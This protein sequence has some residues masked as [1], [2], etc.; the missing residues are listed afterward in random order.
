M[1]DT[2]E[3]EST[4]SEVDRMIETLESNVESDQAPT[5]NGE[6]E[7]DNPES[8]SE[9]GSEE[10]QNQTEETAE[11]EQ[12]E[13]EGVESTKQEEDESDKV[14]EL[15][16][17]IEQ[18]EEQLESDSQESEDSSEEEEVEAEADKENQLKVDFSEED[19]AE[20]EDDLHAELVS[21]PERFSEFLK[22]F[23]EQVSA[24]T[25]E[26]VLEQ[27]PQLV[28]KRVQQR[29]EQRVTLESYWRDNPEL[30]EHRDEMAKAAN[31]VQSDNPSAAL[32]EILEKAGEQV[33][34][35][36]DIEKQADEIDQQAQD[37]P[38]FT[39]DQS[40]GPGQNSTDSRNDQ[41]KELDKM[42]DAI[43]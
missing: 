3:E 28:E 13:D 10:T 1:P 42:L 17:K 33:R 27:I 43:A 11:V 6:E 16:E 14:S 39:P 25:Q 41:Q 2:S 23:G 32:D 20:I 37:N 21:D 18:L 9:D 26:Q 40:T 7:P 12:A 31:E 38:A 5:E 36:L 22:S 4:Q 8:A 29:V 30:R 34:N 19:L 15:E 24:L 35:E